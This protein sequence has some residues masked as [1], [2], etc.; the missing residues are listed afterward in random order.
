M[1]TTCCGSSRTGGASYTPPLD[2]LVSKV[3]ASFGLTRHFAGIADSLRVRESGGSTEQ[4]IGT[5]VDGGFD[6]ASFT[7]FI[8]A[9]NGFART[10]YDQKAGN[11]GSD[12]EQG[13][14]ASQPQVIAASNL[15][16]KAALRFAN[17]RLGG[18]FAGVS[19]S[20]LGTGDFE[21]WIV[22]HPTSSAG[23]KCVAIIGGLAYFYTTTSG[24]GKAGI[25]LSSTG[26]HTFNQAVSANVSHLLRFYRVSGTVFCDVDGATAPNSWAM[27]DNLVK[28]ANYFWGV[29]GT[30]QFAGDMAEFTIFSSALTN[31]ERDALKTALADYYNLT[32]A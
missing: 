3:W 12:L 29:T 8:G 17:T 5:L 32:V 2:A 15:N 25:Y 18:T 30:E 4:D 21:V 19:M 31:A 24:N 28:A 27:S 22:A 14:A 20:A 11:T 13:T 23:H 7:G 1:M 9:N 16:G 26:G 10:A 6:V